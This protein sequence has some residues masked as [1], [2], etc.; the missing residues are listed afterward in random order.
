[1]I[2]LNKLVLLIFGTVIASIGYASPCSDLYDTKQYKSAIEICTEAVQN[3]K[4]DTRSQFNLG[5]MYENGLGVAQNYS[6]ALYWYQQASNN[7][8]AAAQ[9][10]LGVMY[11]QAEDN[12]QA[13]YWYE[14]AAKQ[15]YAQAQLNLGI[16]YSQGIGV[17]LDESKAVY[18]YQKAADQ[19][20]MAAQYN[21][22]YMFENG[23]GVAKSLPKSLYWYQKAAAQ[24]DDS[25]IKSVNRLR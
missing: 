21:L 7:G 14:K 17:I 12:N 23:E 2:K 1:M 16:M 6:K 13:I 18:W 5:V 8:L 3:N 4:N 20:L 25:A 10:N 15:G 24:G 11:S 22:G 19:G 9:Y